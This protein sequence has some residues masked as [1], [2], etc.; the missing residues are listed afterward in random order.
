MAI[1]SRRDTRRRKQQ[2]PTSCRS[3]LS[4]IWAYSISLLFHVM[5]TSFFVQPPEFQLKPLPGTNPVLEGARWKQYHAAMGST[6]EN[7]P[8][9]SWEIVREEKAE[10]MLHILEFPY[11]GEPPKVVPPLPRMLAFHSLTT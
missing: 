2:L 4:V 10:D 1:L 7:L 8:A 5:L 3:M 9:E 6:L 11:N